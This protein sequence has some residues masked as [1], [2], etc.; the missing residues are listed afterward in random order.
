MTSWGTSDL[1]VSE[2]DM[3]LQMFIYPIFLFVPTSGALTTC[4]LLGFI[5]SSR[6]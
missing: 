2:M 4:L 1:K 5:E 3:H 6:T